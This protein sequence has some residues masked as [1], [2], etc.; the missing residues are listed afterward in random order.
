[1]QRSLK[2][3]AAPPSSRHR[4]RWALKL[5][6]AQSRSLVPSMAG[7]MAATYTVDLPRVTEALRLLR[8]PQSVA[9]ALVLGEI[10]GPPKCRRR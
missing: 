9:T 3:E 4:C 1:M 2:L 6:A 5:E 8:A 7:R 10:L